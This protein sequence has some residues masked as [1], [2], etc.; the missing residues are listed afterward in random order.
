M[1]GPART[2]SAF[3]LELMETMHQKVTRPLISSKPDA[4]LVKSPDAKQHIISTPISTRR[5][6]CSA[7]SVYQGETITTGS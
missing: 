2:L 7:V 1:I 4:Y 3:E 6:Q 5:L